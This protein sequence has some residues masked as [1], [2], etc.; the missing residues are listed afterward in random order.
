MVRNT[1]VAEINGTSID[2]G[3]LLTGLDAGNYE[4]AFSLEKFGIDI[5]DFRSNKEFATYVGDLGSVVERYVDEEKN[6]MGWVSRDDA[7]LAQHYS[8][9][10]SDVDM[11]GNADSYAMD[12]DSNLTFAENLSNYVSGDT[13]ADNQRYTRFA[14]RIG[15]GTWDGSRFS[16]DTPQYREAL[17]TEV[18]NF[19]MAFQMR[20][21]AWEGITTW[22]GTYHYS[23]TSEWVVDYFIEDMASKVAS[24]NSN[25]E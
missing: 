19:A 20:E 7:A 4:T 21:G 22:G 13:R 6:W 12:Y 10:A 11:A 23:N 2:I 14:E 25:S 3:H 18:Y 1:K 17:E 15:L 5:F 9:L 8:E 24:E 16:N